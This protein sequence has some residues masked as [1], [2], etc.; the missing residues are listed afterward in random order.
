MGKTNPSDNADHEI[1]LERIF[2][3]PC[4]LVWEAWTNPKHGA[5]WWGPDGFTMT[6]EKMDFRVGGV[7][8]HVM[9]GPDGTDYPNYSVF[10]KIVEHER[11]VF[12]HSGGDDGRTDIAFI[13]TW[14][15]EAVG[16][17]T[18]LN[19]R[20]PFANSAAREVATKE[21]G[22]IEGGRQT[23]A[24]LEALVTKMATA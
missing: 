8:K 20:L 21:Y 11:I 17:K 3:A 19:M 5:Q 6:I 7:W 12:E 1:V 4:E 15:F 18:R 24:R 22:A 23:L 10:R 14:T 13:A 16:N 9:H 2:D